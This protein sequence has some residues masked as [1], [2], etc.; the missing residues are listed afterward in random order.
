MSPKFWASLAHS[1]RHSVAR[2]ICSWRLCITA[3]APCSS[4]AAL[5]SSTSW[6]KCGIR[7]TPCQQMT[8]HI[9]AAPCY[10]LQGQ[11]LFV[12]CRYICD[13]IVPVYLL[14][15]FL[16]PSMQFFSTCPAN[17]TSSA[18]KRHDDLAWKRRM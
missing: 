9:L 2:S 1:A 4:P 14:N 16:T 18:F 8:T 15:S 11:H 6:F 3:T 12:V 10:G 17:R 13:Q 7:L 5:P